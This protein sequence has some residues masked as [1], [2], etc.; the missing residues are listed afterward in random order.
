MNLLDY[1]C[2]IS[3][4]INM[5]SDSH[6]AHLWAAL[7]GMSFD[8]EGMQRRRDWYNDQH[9]KVM[10]FLVQECQEL[11][12]QDRLIICDLRMGE[13]LEHIMQTEAEFRCYRELQESLLK[14]DLLRKMSCIVAASS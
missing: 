9:E 12:Q 11:Q 10:E 7:D 2:K 5:L 8:E 4:A 14:S 3:N 13:I 1:V 6:A